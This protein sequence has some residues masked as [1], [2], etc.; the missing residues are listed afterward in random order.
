MQ[1]PLQ[2]RRIMGIGRIDL[3]KKKIDFHPIGPA[4]ALGFAVVA[5][6]ASAATA[7]FADIDEYEFWTFDLE[8]TASSARTPFRGRPRMGHARQQQRQLI[9]I[10]TAG[11]TIDLYDARRSSSCAR[12]R[13][14]AT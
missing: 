11:N 9:Y 10:H 14:T 5:A 2:N 4:R 12:S 1:D 13:S 7:C 6:I 8:T 3:A